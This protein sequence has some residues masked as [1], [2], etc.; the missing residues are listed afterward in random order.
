MYTFAVNLLSFF[1]LK[2]HMTAAVQSGWLFYYSSN[3]H[4]LLNCCWTNFTT[5]LIYIKN[6]ELP[7]LTT[8]CGST[9][10][11]LRLLF[12][13]NTAFIYK[14]YTFHMKMW[15]I[16]FSV[17]WNGRRSTNRNAQSAG[18]LVS[19]YSYSCGLSSY[20]NMINWDLKS[21]MVV[22]TSVIL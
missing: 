1:D 2:C 12:T 11:N 7:K 9:V 10:F 15:S 19:D 16:H 22:L 4:N 13:M 8:R 18:T 14:D 3:K 5:K 20:P 21:E 17:C 6:K